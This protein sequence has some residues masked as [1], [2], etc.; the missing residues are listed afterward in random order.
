MTIE[1][2]DAK[3]LEKE[4]DDAGGVDEWIMMKAEQNDTF[5]GIELNEANVA[6]L[7]KLNELAKRLSDLEP[8]ISYTWTPLTNKERHGTVTLETDLMGFLTIDRRVLDVLSDMYHIADMVNMNVAVEGKDKIIT[9]F[10]VQEMW[11]KFEYRE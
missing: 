8:D 7:N 5:R 11:D 3:K 10:A 1:N 2:F 6:R 9:T 4:I